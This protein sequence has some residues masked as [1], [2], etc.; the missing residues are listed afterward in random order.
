MISAPAGDDTGILAHRVSRNGVCCPDGEPS[1]VNFGRY[2][3][4]AGTGIGKKLQIASARRWR[5]MVMECDVPDDVPPCEGRVF[6][7][8]GMSGAGKTTVGEILSTRLRKAGLPV[9]FLDGDRLRAAIAPD[10]GHDPEQ[11]RRLAFS[12]ARLSREL[13]RQDLIV[14]IATVSMFHDVRDWNRANIGGYRE[15][16]LHVPLEYRMARDPKGLYRRSTVDMVGV[17]IAAEIPASPDLRI[18][19]FGTMAPDMAAE[20]IWDRLIVPDAMLSAA[21]RL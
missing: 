18:D 17:D 3:G 2:G 4:N 10:A 19:N 1:R 8:T 14:V 20:L 16:Y 11:R 12:Y 9:A 21:C 6:W 7:L 13:A 15:I 5:Q